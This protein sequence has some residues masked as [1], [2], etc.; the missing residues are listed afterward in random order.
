MKKATK[1]AAFLLAGTCLVSTL[2]GCNKVADEIITSMVQW[3]ID[4][5]YLNKHDETY[6]TLSDTTLEEAEA[7]YKEGIGYD[8]DNFAYYW[9]ITDDYVAYADLDAELQDA[10]YNICDTVSK[11][12]KYEIVSAAAQDDGS[13]AVKVVV[14]PIDLMEQINEKY[15]TYAPLN[16]FFARTESLDYEAMSDEEYLAICNEYGYILVDL[17]EETL[18]NLGY[19]ESKS[20]TIQM[21]LI[22]DLWTMNE[23]DFSNFSTY[24][25]SYPY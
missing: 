18:P 24:V 23:D 12:S 16:D 17:A 8:A 15:E 25:V 2:S 11:S 5:V 7:T 22:D 4:S 19:L 6:L 10:I 1:T 13:Y 14:E 20:L 9:G 3:T 21:E